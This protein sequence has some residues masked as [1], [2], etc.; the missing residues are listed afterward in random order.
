[1]VLA[2][3][4]SA[5]QVVAP[6]PEGPGTLV[7]LVVDSLGRPVAN[8]TVYIVS[9]R[10]SKVT[11]ANGSF[12]FDSLPEG[13]YRVGARAIGYISG[14][15]EV[16]VDAKGGAAII[17]MTRFSTTLPSVSTTATRTGLSGVIADTSYRALDSVSVHAVG[18]GVG[19][20]M[21][22]SKGEF[23]LP[24]KPGDYIVRIE[25][26]GYAHQLIGVTVPPREG[27]RIAAWMS[28]SLRG[29]TAMDGKAFFDMEQRLIRRSPAYSKVY[30]HTEL[31]RLGI[32]DA[33]QAWQ[34]FLGR[35]AG[36]DEC[37]YLNGGPQSV[38]LW[39][40]DVAEIESFEVYGDRA[41]AR[42]PNSLS[43]AS[44][45]G[46]AVTNPFICK[47]WVWLRS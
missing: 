24:V 1:M 38:P 19:S 4:D 47:N 18:S 7:G 9:P 14:T 40:L 16:P 42:G 39:A 37:A 13:K 21:T 11:R 31:T 12:R 45:I 23:Y 2:P 27:R 5:A 6:K 33:L 36:P 3:R 17:E 43:G 41:S 34:R 25:R 44:Q 29:R 26:R 10:R 30:S 8:A 35:Q 20:T 46:A 22:N 28:P 32:P 15:G